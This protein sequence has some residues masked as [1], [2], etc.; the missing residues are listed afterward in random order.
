M[1]NDELEIYFRKR[2]LLLRD[3]W[4]FEIAQQDYILRLEFMGLFETEYVIRGFEDL[5]TVHYD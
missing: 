5:G 2:S 4:I 3:P 1:T